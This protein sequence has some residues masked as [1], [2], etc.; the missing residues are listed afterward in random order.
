M[1]TPD[2]SRNDP[3]MTTP[4]EPEPPKPDTGEP[5]T[6]PDSDQ[7]GDTPGVGKLLVSDLT[8]WHWT[9]RVAG[10]W[11]L[12][13]IVLIGDGFSEADQAKVAPIGLLATLTA[14][15]AL[16]R[17]RILK[18]TIDASTKRATNY[19]DWRKAMQKPLEAVI[20]LPLIILLAGA[21]S[22]AEAAH[23]GADAH[24]PAI[25]SFL[26]GLFAWTAL[27]GLVGSAGADAAALKTST[28]QQAGVPQCV[29]TAWVAG[30]VGTFL[31]ACMCGPRLSHPWGL[32]PWAICGMTLGL[33]ALTSTWKVTAP[34]RGAGDRP[35]IWA[36][37][38][39]WCKRYWSWAA[40]VFVWAALTWA[41]GSVF[42]G[43]EVWRLLTSL[44]AALT[45]CALIHS[46][47]SHP[48]MWVGEALT[49]LH[50]DVRL[51]WREF[52]ELLRSKSGW[53][54]SLP[55]P[56]ALRSHWLSLGLFT[57]AV[58]CFLAIGW[59]ANTITKLANP[60]ATGPQAVPTSVTCTVPPQSTAPTPQNSAASSS[61][62]TPTS[63]PTPASQ[64][65]SASNTPT[66]AY[67]Y[68]CH[69]N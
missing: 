45:M 1:V 19:I 16:Y 33:W 8:R 54:T 41:I 42:P 15:L 43:S 22:L 32:I 61:T 36:T 20:G 46:L 44:V 24:S 10:F 65:N 62:P 63:L 18:P 66:P 37:V 17:L 23:S 30:C 35:G 6:Q 13:S 14:A 39:Q 53:R 49:H 64:S 69:P 28:E 60:A 7:T 31:A 5:A 21:M 38:W 58:V 2:P 25:T 55:Q 3:M 11:L 9:R 68:I 4:T 47:A 29:T 57:A 12:M 48:D 56:S 40:A 34:S 26:V 27:S 51:F 50:E 52:S 59:R 67:T